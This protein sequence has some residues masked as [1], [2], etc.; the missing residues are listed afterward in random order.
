MSQLNKHLGRMLAT[1]DSELCDLV[2]RRIVQ[3][4]GN[5]ADLS[6]LSTEEKVVDLVMRAYGIIGNGGFQY[7]FEGTFEGDPYFNK[8]VAAFE[9]IGALECAQALRDE[10]SIFPNSKPP[11]DIER[12]LMIYD[13]KTGAKVPLK[14]R[15]R[16]GNKDSAFHPIDRFFNQSHDI[17]K[18]LATYIWQNRSALA[19]CFGD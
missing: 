6:D 7:L 12:R 8:T 18:L 14:I 9:A 5:E 2:W 15:M 4:H 19:S 1:K 3:C 10:L 16:I 11:R 13:E 17:E